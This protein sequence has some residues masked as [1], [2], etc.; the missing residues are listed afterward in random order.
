VEVV[1]V[2][3]EVVLPV[4]SLMK[5]P[6][7]AYS[8]G[9]SFQGMWN[10]DRRNFSLRLTI[11]SVDPKT[12]TLLATIQSP[13]L[14]NSEKQFEGKVEGDGRKMVLTGVAESGAEYDDV[15]G[16]HVTDL[17]RKGATQIV[18]LNDCD[19]RQLRGTT[20]DGTNLYFWTPIRG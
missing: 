19:T 16:Y 5:P 4:G 9:D 10:Y 2:D 3:P 11:T 1:P 20:E 6:P 18:D 17:L 15:D 14:D 8:P 7:I 12:R 13:D